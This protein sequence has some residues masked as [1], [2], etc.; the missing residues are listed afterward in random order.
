MLRRYARAVAT[1]RVVGDRHVAMMAEQMVEW[2]GTDD[3]RCTKAGILQMLTDSLTR[4][5]VTENQ[6]NE[7]GSERSDLP[8]QS[9]LLTCL[10]GLSEADAGWV[11]RMSADELRAGLELE[12]RTLAEVAPT[13][14]LIIEDEFFISRDLARIVSE[15]GH[16][17]TARAKTRAQAAAAVEQQRPGLI[18]A[19]VTLADG[20]SGVETVSDIDPRGEIPTIFITAYPEQLLTGAGAEPTFVIGKPYNV[21]Q[22]RTL[23]GHC[24]SLVARP[25]S[26]ARS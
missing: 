6:S 22:V 14:V 15:L 2:A 23:I 25:V 1:S 16:R 24:L 19:D 7:A 13:E 17:V 11:L 20:S 4:P 3:S 10:E 21:E 8:R 18:L 5:E 12:R 26:V 9:L